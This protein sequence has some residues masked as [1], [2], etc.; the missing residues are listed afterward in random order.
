MNNINPMRNIHKTL[1]RYL[2]ICKKVN[3]LLN[4]L[5]ILQFNCILLTLRE[6]PSNF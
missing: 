4:V 2:V 6:Y 3:L 1:E 5:I